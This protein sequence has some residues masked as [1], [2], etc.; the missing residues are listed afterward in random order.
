MSNTLTHSLRLWGEVFTE[1]NFHQNVPAPDSVEVNTSTAR[2]CAS[3]GCSVAFKTIL[4]EEMQNERA[5]DR[6]SRRVRAREDI[7]R[8][9]IQNSWMYNSAYTIEPAELPQL[10]GESKKHLSTWTAL[11]IT[12]NYI[13]TG[14][15]KMINKLYTYLI[16]CQQSI[17]ISPLTND[18]MFYIPFIKVT[19]PSFWEE[20]WNIFFFSKTE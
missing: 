5:T 10:T 15:L 9:F 13:I 12:S 20:L 8:G 11:H 1:T 17:S 2:S 3:R 6:E 7:Y 19:L 4:A 14:M 18:E 16:K